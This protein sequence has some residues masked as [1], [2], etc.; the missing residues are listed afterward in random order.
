[1]ITGA[2]REAV[3]QSL[4]SLP[5]SAELGLEFL[6]S[7]YQLAPT[8]RLQERGPDELVGIASSHHETAQRRLP[9]ED[10]IR[11]SSPTTSREGWS[12]GGSVIEIVTEDRHFLVDSVR[13]V[14]DA[15]GHRVQELYHPIFRVTRDD[16]GRL[17]EVGACHGEDCAGESWMHL[18]VPRIS[19]EAETAAVREALEVALRDVRATVEDWSEM[20]ALMW[21]SANT[22]EDREQAELLRWLTDDE[23]T[24]LGRARYTCVDGTTPQ[25]DETSLLG[26]A[27]H[28]PH[29]ADLPLDTEARREAWASTQVLVTE[30]ADRSTVERARYHDIIC[31]KQRD[32]H[33]TCV[34]EE[35]FIGL[36]ANTVS[37]GST[38]RIPMLRRVASTVLEKLEVARE[39]H[40]GREVMQ[41]VDSYPRQPL[42]H[43]D[44]DRLA[45]TALEIRQLREHP[46]ARLFVEVEPLQRYVTFVVHQPRDRYSTSSRLA[47]TRVLVDAVDGVDVEFAT[48]VTG[49]PLATLH[50]TIRVPEG[51]SVPEIDKDALEAQLDLI[52]RSW[53]EEF[54]TALEAVHGDDEG[55][56]LWTVYGTAFGP[57]YTETTSVETGAEDGAVLASLPED[58]VEVR[59]HEDPEDEAVRRLKLYLPNSA[60]LSDLMPVFTS[61]GITVTEERPHEVLPATEPGEPENPQ[62]ILDLG[63]RADPEVWRRTEDAP[64]RIA[65][66]VRLAWTGEV[67][68]DQLQA[69]VPLSPLTSEQIVILRA[70]V[71][72][73]RQL[74]VTYSPSHLRKVL[75]AYPDTAVALVELFRCRFSPDLDGNRDAACEAVVERIAEQLDAV[76][77][78]DHERI[79]GACRDVILATQRTNYYQGEP[80]GAVAFKIATE[81]LSI[82]PEPRPYRELW[83]YS[84]RVEGVHLRFGSVARGGLRWSDRREDFRTE[85][86]GLV[87]AQVVKNAVIVPAGAKGGFYAKK[88]GSPQ[89]DRDAWY[90]EGVGAYKTFISA[91]LSVTDNR[92]GDQVVPPERVVRHDEDDPY[93]VVAADKGTATFSDTANEIAVGRG[94]WL[95]DAFASGGSAGFDHK[96]MGITA[97]GAWESVRRHF[98]ERGHDTQGEDFTCVGIGDMSGDV[99]GNGLLRTPHARLVAAFDHRHVFVDPN[100]DAAASFEERQRLFDK[101]RST[102][103]DYDRS[104][105]SEGGGVW[106]RDAKSVPISPQMREAL[107]IEET[108]LS[109]VE[110]IRA[111]LRA[112]VDLVW[113]G[114]IGTYVKAESE[115][116]ADVG[117]RA[118]DAVRVNGSEL[119]ATIVGEGGN[120]GFTQRG[121]IE[122]ALNGVAINT[123]AIDNSAGVDTSDHEVNIKILLAEAIR[124]GQLEADQRDDMLAAMIDEV[125]DHVL[126]TNYE[127]NVLIGNARTQGERM[128]NQHLRLMHL[129]EDRVDLDR[130]LEALPSDDE[131]LS[132]AKQTGSGLTSP[133]FSVL[134]AWT[135]IAL[136]QALL[137]GELVDDPWCEQMLLDYFPASITERFADLVRQHPLRREIIANVVA[138][139]VVNRGGVSFV[140]RAMEETSATEEAV[141]RAFLVT[142]SVFGLSEFVGA[143]EK[144]DNKVSTDVQ[145]DLYLTFRRLL[146]QAVRRLAARPVSTPISEQVEF[147][148]GTV[149]GAWG[150]IG[151]FLRGSE[152]GEYDDRVTTLQEAGVPKELAV[153]TAELP[154]AFAL[155]DVADLADRHEVAFD[156]VADA[157]FA[158]V[159]RLRIGALLSAIGRL[160]SADQWEAMARNSARSDA[161]QILVELSSDVLSGEGPDRIDAWFAAHDRT[162]A[163]AVETVTAVLE[164]EHAQ[165][166]PISVALRAL[167]NLKD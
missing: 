151:Q 42:F 143:V 108:S 93:L 112:P 15:M 63:L 87:K 64:Q 70:V 102:W 52:G 26:V 94:F 78:L 39:S 83:V 27:R 16:E 126:R 123:D 134:V 144:L 154:A 48:Q 138:N 60:T 45:E 129:L 153:Q 92:D 95:G 156:D 114:G 31:V 147:Y 41:L 67:E 2:D 116:H 5:G 118:N 160:S 14:L 103:D 164:Q 139:E 149:D 167:R 71:S 32:E 81:E 162:A 155:L 10:L 28:H 146:D 47:I 56:R 166:A 136:K 117:D 23:F 132:R 20:S 88:A 158:L 19:D 40:A 68:A 150:R 128:V 9:G 34:A 65:D 7:Y 86:L 124:Q 53:N 113:N 148:S 145:A 84:P 106:S 6:R 127:Q 72:Y 77:S 37:S 38:A 74:G 76:P 90:T 44:V 85:V 46:R 25:L 50:F 36:L 89:A 3:F 43:A 33:G 111:V 30:G 109:P 54:Q 29:A 130:R 66:A 98:R 1:M 96:G 8:E 161:Y 152:I 80:T 157:W 100:P 73:L 107:G 110:L 137:E 22:V 140:F 11:I 97:R 21:A 142:R 115:S 12:V 62:F 17:I 59:L 91:L 135:K 75:N 82:A 125:A 79:L 57:D 122:A 69:L 105:I 61:L 4:A 101:P 35:R 49:S 165:L 119:R 58:G 159:D 55:S 133:E 131:L 18:L 51:T 13:G 104:L 24:F 121:R 163:K 141:V 120:L 99:F